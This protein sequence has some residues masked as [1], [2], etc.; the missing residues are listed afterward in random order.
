MPGAMCG[1]HSVLWR[2]PQVAKAERQAQKAKGSLVTDS[3]G[4]HICTEWAHGSASEG[5]SG[6]RIPIGK[7]GH[8][9]LAAGFGEQ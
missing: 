8:F 3:V 6:V 7:A 2:C 4:T 9:W 1:A 5:H